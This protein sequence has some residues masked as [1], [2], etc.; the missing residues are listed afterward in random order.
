MYFEHETVR[1]LKIIFLAF[2]ARS[3][4]RPVDLPEVTQLLPTYPFPRP[5]HVLALVAQEPTINCRVSPVP[6]DIPWGP[7]LQAIRH[8]IA[9]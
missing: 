4:E 2:K 5:C 6:G 7:Q 8:T 1:T 9:L 3:P